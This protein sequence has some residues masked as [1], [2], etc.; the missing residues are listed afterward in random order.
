VRFIEA[1][2]AAPFFL[3]I[4]HSMP[5]VPLARSDAFVDHSA[6][7]IYGD[8]VE[9]ID[10]SVGEVLDA[11]ARAGIARNTLVLFTSDNG[12]WLPYRTH[13]GSPGELHGGKGT[14]WEGGVRTPAIFWWPGTVEP[15]VVTGIGSALDVFAT[16]AALAKVSV[17][18]DRRLDSVDLGPALV[19][20]APSPRD[21]IFYYWDSELRAVRKG[22]YKAH[23]I[24][25]G[26]Y[27]EGESRTVHDPPLLFD[28]ATDPAERFD[29]AQHHPE[30]VASLID[31]AAAHRRTVEPAEPLF[32]LLLE[33]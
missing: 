10:W 7:G 19:G 12:P 9:E 15:H 5:H 33:R 29:I 27:G 8:V 32:D 20:G 11:L 30:V 17:P 23:F 6:G 26:A 25:S 3:Y 16:A 4:A 31:L 24:T 22:R 2:A 18:G 21:E 28:L 14:T 13:G 1:N